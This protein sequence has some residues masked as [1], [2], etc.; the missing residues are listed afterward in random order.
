MTPLVSRRRTKPF[1]PA[2]VL[3]LL[4][5]AL[6]MAAGCTS[7]LGTPDGQTGMTPITPM[8]TVPARS[9]TT[10]I[11]PAVTMSAEPEP[12]PEV[13]PQE[14]VAA[15]TVSSM[16]KP[17]STNYHPD[18]ITMDAN[19]YKVGEVVLFY[20]VNRGPEI[21]GCDYSHPAYSV[22]HL[23]PDGTRLVVSTSDPNRSYT[24]V[25][26]GDPG[27]STGPFSLGTGRLSPGRY[28]I[29]FDCGNNVGRE[30]VLLAR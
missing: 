24:T 30:F 1:Y 4:L 12:L 17:L 26:S 16:T 2:V 6:L 14:P 29:R 11:P 18:Y 15:V 28:L 5:A 27:S 23:S 3:M 13:T 21:R 22:Y 7:D 20:L 10:T 25:M 19:V 9:V 8:K